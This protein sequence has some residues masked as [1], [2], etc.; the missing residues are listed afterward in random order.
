MRSA[1]ASS[2]TACA[3]P[4]PDGTAG[5]PAPRG[6]PSLSR[7]ATSDHDEYLAAFAGLGLKGF[8]L[9]RAERPWEVARGRLASCIVEHGVDGAAWAA[10][11]S[12]AAGTVTVAF[13]GS[14]EADLRIDGHGTSQNELHVWPAGSR[15]FVVSRRPADWFVVTVATGEGL[16]PGLDRPGGAGAWPA[17][18]DELDRL[19]T[20]ATSALRTCEEAGPCGL[21]SCE[22][23]ALEEP[24]LAGLARLAA[25][26]RPSPGGGRPRVD[27]RLV[28]EQ[29]DALLEKRASE[30]LYVA[31]LCAATG[32]PERTLRYVL[33]GE[34]GT[35]P[36][37]L[38]RDRRLCELR[39]RLREE[40][41]AG[42]SLARITAG[43]GFRH[44]R[45][46][47]SDYRRLFGELPSETRRSAAPRPPEGAPGLH[48]TA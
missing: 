18:A 6:V 17:R 37:R 25:R 11:G 44:M 19:R 48:A 20:L 10:R 33:V 32:L 8:L 9:A 13:P 23:E 2:T 47:A 12:T 4:D 39:R 22:A 34:Y 5:M 31:D 41:S 3:R 24:I 27:R 45:S 36:V 7:V 16:P 29:V 28:L 1:L 14:R 40:E 46:L 38:L 26:P 15:V 43:H 35:S 30:V 42:A 21:A